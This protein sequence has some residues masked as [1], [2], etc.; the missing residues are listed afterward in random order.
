MSERMKGV[1]HL[2]LF[3]NDTVSFIFA[4]LGN[5]GAWSRALIAKNCQTAQEDLVRRWGFA[6][7]KAIATIDELRRSGHAHRE[8]DVDAELVARLFPS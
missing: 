1:L 2:Q 8:A 6:P 7:S 3:T 5:H 4:P